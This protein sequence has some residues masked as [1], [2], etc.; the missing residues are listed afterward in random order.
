MVPGTYR[1]TVHTTTV[2]T[3]T[4][5]FESFILAARTTTVQVLY[6]YVRL[7]ACTVCTSTV[8][9]PGTYLP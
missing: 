3:R 1:T 6:M 8:R 4:L 7:H 5:Y 2:R 9:L